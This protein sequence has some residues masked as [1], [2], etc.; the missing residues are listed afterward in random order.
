MRSF[1][2]AEHCKCKKR[3][4][5]IVCKFLLYRTHYAFLHLEM[6]FFVSEVNPRLPTWLTDESA[7]HL[8]ARVVTREQYRRLLDWTIGHLLEIM[9]ILCFCVSRHTMPCNSNN[10][11]NIITITTTTINSSTPISPS[12]TVWM[13]SIIDWMRDP[14]NSSNRNS[15]NNSNNTNNNSNILQRWSISSH[16]S[17]AKSSRLAMRDLAPTAKTTTT[18]ISK[19]GISI[20]ITIIIQRRGIRRRD[21]STSSAENEYRRK[22]WRSLTTGTGSWSENVGSWQR[23]ASPYLKIERWDYLRIFTSA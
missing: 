2:S 18:T 21:T 17:S 4:V 22:A 9:T 7:V 20:I 11:I 13:L 15:N 5:W 23:A 16:M 3:S 1:T 8:I 6:N 12:H 10:N 14:P 19:T